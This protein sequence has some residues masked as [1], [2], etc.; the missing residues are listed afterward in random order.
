MVRGPFCWAFLEEQLLRQGFVCRPNTQV[1]QGGKSLHRQIPVTIQLQRDL[2]HLLGSELRR[3]AT[4][5]GVLAVATPIVE[6]LCPPI[7]S[8]S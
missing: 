6:S 2:I 7:D 3:V 1:D 4:P 8:A 5:G